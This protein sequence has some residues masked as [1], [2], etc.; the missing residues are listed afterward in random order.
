MLVLERGRGGGGGRGGGE[1]ERER[2]RGRGSGK[3][4]GRGRGRREKRE[5]GNKDS[6]I[7]PLKAIQVRPTCHS[8]SEHLLHAQQDF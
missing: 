6:G 8:S 1:G 4:R 3:G 5:G 2:E 7:L